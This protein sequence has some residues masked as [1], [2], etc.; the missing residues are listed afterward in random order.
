MNHQFTGSFFGLGILGLHQGHE[1]GDEGKGIH[2]G[3]RDIQNVNCVK[4]FP[5]PVVKS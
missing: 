5:T 4:G 1:G 3:V 2:H